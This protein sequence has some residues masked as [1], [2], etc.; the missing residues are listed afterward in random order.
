[1]IYAELAAYNTFKRKLRT[2]LSLI[3]LHFWQESRA[4]LEFGSKVA[5]PTYSWHMLLARCFSPL[6]ITEVKPSLTGFVFGW[7]TA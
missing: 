1:M 6:G 7:V 5:M 4:M 2:E 3:F